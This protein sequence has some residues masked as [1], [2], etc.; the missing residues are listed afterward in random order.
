MKLINFLLLASTV[1]D[2]FVIPVS[3]SY[4]SCSS[5]PSIILQSHPTKQMES[6]LATAFISW[7]IM[8]SQCM[9]IPS[10]ASEAPIIRGT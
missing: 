9:A 1:V 3:F 10:I 6:A 2:A 4:N 8:S 7:T 5:S